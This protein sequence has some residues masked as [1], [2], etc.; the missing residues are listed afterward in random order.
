[1][2]VDRSP[3]IRGVRFA[4]PVELGLDVELRARLRSWVARCHALTPYL[5][6][7]RQT[8]EDDA[9]HAVLRR[10]LITLAH[11]VAH[12]LAPDVEV[13]VEGR[14]IREQRSR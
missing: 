2:L 6:G 13:L 11:D 3:G 8:P 9:A 5:I 1:M 4:D 7:E 12:Q 10:D 14:P